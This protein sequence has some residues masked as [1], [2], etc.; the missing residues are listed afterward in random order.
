MCID[1]LKKRNWFLWIAIL[2]VNISFAQTADFTFASADNF[3]CTPYRVICTQ[4]CTGNPTGFV[5]DFGNGQQGLN[6]TELTVYTTPGTYSVTLTAL[7]SNKAVSVTK[8]LV[9]NPTPEVNV[10]ADKNYL[11][12]PG[13]VQFTATASSSITNYEWSFGDEGGLQNSVSN[14]AVHAYRDYGTYTAKVKATT[15]A[16]CAAAGNYDITI[17]KLGITTT[18]SNDTGCIPALTSL[19]AIAALPPGD[20]VLSYVWNFGDNTPSARTTAASVNHLYN[21]T[22]SINSASVTINSAQGCSNTFNFQP[23]AFGTP[24]YN[25]VAATAMA[26]GTF[27]ASETV[28]F[29]CKAVNA[30]HYSWDWGDSTQSDV[31]D[32]LATHK[33][34]TLGNKRIIV[35]PYLNGCAGNKDTLN[36]FI[37]GVVANFNYSNLCSSKQT[38]LFNNTSLGSSARFNWQFS[39]TPGLQDSVNSNLTHIFPLAGSFNV[40]LNV[41]DNFSTCTDSVNYTIY[42]AVPVLTRT[43]TAV[44]KDSLVVYSV[45]NSYPDSAGYTYE[46]HVTGDTVNTNTDSVLN[47]HPAK[48][49][50]FADFVIIKDA[51]PGTCDDT[52]HL[53]SNSIVR[54]PVV[55]FTSAPRMCADK[56]F[57]FTNKSYPYNTNETVSNWQWQFGDSTSSTLKNP[58]PHKYPKPGLYT[59]SLVGTD[60]N[61]CVQ[62]QQKDVLAD[63]LPQVISFPAMD[64]ICQGRDT[65]ILTGYTID[66]L[67]WL[68]ATNISCNFCDTTKVYPF[69]TTAYIAQAKN[70]F[71]CIS[72]DTSI[73]KVYAPLKVKVFPSDTTICPGQSIAYMLNTGGIASWSPGNYL[74]STTVTN[75]IAKPTAD[76]TYTVIV[77]DSVGCFADTA[78]ANAHVFAL[79][80]VDAGPDKIYSYNNSFTIT[81]VYS[82]GV[83]SYS[84]EPSTN[85]NCSNCPNPSGNALQTTTYTIKTTSVNGCTSSDKITIFIACENGN[86][87]LPTAFSPNGNGINEYFY[88]IARG[89]KTIKKFVIFNRRGNKVFERQNFAPNIRSLGWDGRVNNADNVADSE[90]FAWYMEAECEQG[91]LVTNKGTVVLIR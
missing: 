21:T 88:P 83:A 22:D 34:R 9:I 12:K 74:N 69:T 15:A 75:P 65:A 35:T 68:P 90:T 79:P 36:I 54:G 31:A 45:I 66:S 87:L 59:I 18:I 48:H 70:R 71:G 11:C 57:T 72:Y 63:R 89:Y 56:P 81:P 77:K 5:W 3:H 64:T 19:S 51:L 37:K 53:S 55:D 82:A 27:C 8:T 47:H 78:I 85:L 49:G 80:A 41:I 24:P 29:S 4:S 26:T 23:F 33:Y 20:N 10:T 7:Y 40:S 17:N 44:C 73:I 13:A 2:L 6:A 61:G 62:K 38:Y 32:T 46:F 39:D 67:R 58:T 52:L 30:N 1:L 86:L 50:S 16:G 25:T 43:S 14:R 28:A 76:I 60:I 91:Q 42:T 84:W